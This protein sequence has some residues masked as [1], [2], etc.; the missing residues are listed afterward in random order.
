M[1]RAARRTE[2]Y[3]EVDALRGIAIIMMI[4]YHFVWDLWYW[5]VL[6]N[7]VLWDGFWKYW[8]RLTA[9]T[10]LVLLGI[11]LTIA[12]RRERRRQG[13]D[14]RLYPQFF[15]RG[16]KI[17]GLGM[18]ITLVVTVARVGY[19]DFGILHLLGFA[20]MASY[21]LLR[22]KWLNLGLWAVFSLAGKSIANVRWDGMW[23][24]PHFGNWLGEP[25]FVDGRW[26]VPL[27]VTPTDYAAVDYFP[28]VPWFGVV[29][30]GVFLG[31]L[32]YSAHVRHFSLGNWGDGFPFSAFEF[33]G[34]HSLLIYLVHQ[35]LL[36]LALILVGVLH[37]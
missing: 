17:F 30:L 22:F 12:Y 11:S 9:G 24:I 1:A 35:P 31:N 8:Q 16:V 3:W 34:R 2:R 29:L 15:W 27:G 13:T 4:I 25:L 21:P 18:L 7:V 28:I 5:Q 6:P 20:T 23:Y 37:F 10:F 19:V 33:L 26:L 36:L 32:L 14:A